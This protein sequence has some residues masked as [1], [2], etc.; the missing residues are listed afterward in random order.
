[1]TGNCIYVTRVP[2]SSFFGT[3]ICVIRNLVRSWRCVEMA[4]HRATSHRH[5]S[6]G[7]PFFA[8]IL[9]FDMRWKLQTCELCSRECDICENW[10]GDRQHWWKTNLHKYMLCEA[11]KATCSITQRNDDNN[12]I[13]ALSQC[14][15]FVCQSVVQSGAEWHLI[16]LFR[17]ENAIHIVS[18]ALHRLM[19][20]ISVLQCA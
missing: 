20:T 5:P 9:D 4:Q 19:Q 7:S 2:L 11:Y 17:T 13:C 1:M 12:Y 14:S 15:H 16:E 3:Q 8:C 10:T 6:H 18:R